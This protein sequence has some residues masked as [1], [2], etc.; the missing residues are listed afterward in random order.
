M[1][2]PLFLNPV[3]DVSTHI[4]GVLSWY[5][6]KKKNV[7]TVESLDDQLGVEA[8][9]TAIAKTNV[10]CSRMPLPMFW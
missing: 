3:C 4:H 10:G 5:S 1:K 9:H 2:H 6:Q 8:S 7:H